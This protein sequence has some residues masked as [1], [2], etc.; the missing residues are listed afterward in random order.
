M[1]MSMGMNPVLEAMRFAFRAGKVHGCAIEQVLPADVCAVLRE[2]VR[3]GLV[4]YDLPSRARYQVNT[5]HQEPEIARVLAEVAE[6]IV[7][8][9]LA[10]MV[11]GSRWLR[12]AHGDYAL[13]R[14]DVDRWAARPESY[15]LVLDFSAAATAEAHIVYSDGETGFV[16]QQE[17]SMLAV[18]ER[19]AGLRRWDR[20]LTLRVGEAEVFR[21]SLPLS[22]R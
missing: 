19:R 18:V 8:K 21:L 14:D 13:S 17:P 1:T 22:I 11:E 9:P 4:P 16:V 5:T 7:E 12:L 3:P 10:P 20:Y 6:H 15:E 2:R